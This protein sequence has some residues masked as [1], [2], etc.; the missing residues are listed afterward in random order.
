MKCGRGVS[1]VRGFVGGNA[2]DEDERDGTVRVA[3]GD[4]GEC[5][6]VLAAERAG[7]AGEGNNGGGC[8]AV[9]GE[10]VRLSVDIEEIEVRDEAADESFGGVDWNGGA[11]VI[12]LGVCGLLW[13][14][15]SECGGDKEQ[16]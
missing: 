1:H 2:V 11:A 12:V 6:E 4:A 9:I 14:R 8:L 16:A 10:F 3:F 13:E 7:G 5:G 15:Q